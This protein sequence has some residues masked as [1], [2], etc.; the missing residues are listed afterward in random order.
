MPKGTIVTDLKIHA[1]TRRIFAGTHGHGI[2]RADLYDNPQYVYALSQKVDRKAF[3]SVYPNPS[4]GLVKVI[5]DN[6]RIPVESLKVI[7]FTGREV[8]IDNQFKG[9]S[10]VDMTKFPTGAY[11]IQLKIDTEII[12]KKVVIEK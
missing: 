11:M 6:D 2:W 5:W 1:G 3:L 7:D 10:V 4:N 9:K 12:A 8:F